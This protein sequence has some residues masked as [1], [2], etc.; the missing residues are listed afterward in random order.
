[1]TAVAVGAAAVIALV[2]LASRGS[3]L[4]FERRALSGA[5][6]PVRS[7]WPKRPVTRRRT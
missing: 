2:L 4:D 6:K 1:M 7:K 5:Y 3:G